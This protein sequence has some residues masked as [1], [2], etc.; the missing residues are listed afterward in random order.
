LGTEDWLG[1]LAAFEN[2]RGE[3]S[4]VRGECEHITGPNEAETRGK[5]SRGENQ[6]KSSHIGKGVNSEEGVSKQ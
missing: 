3:L 2:L 5:P 6:S 4:R 1:L